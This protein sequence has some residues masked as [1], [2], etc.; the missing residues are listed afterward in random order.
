MLSNKYTSKQ[1]NE[2]SIKG[3]IVPFMN[4]GLPKVIFLNRSACSKLCN[5]YKTAEGEYFEYREARKIWQFLSYLTTIKNKEMIDV[6]ALFF[7]KKWCKNPNIK[8]VNS[9]I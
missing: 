7:S 1:T 4:C 9:V 6:F 5:L 3:Y 2:Y 8:S